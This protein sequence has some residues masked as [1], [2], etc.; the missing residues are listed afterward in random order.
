MTPLDVLVTA[1]LILICDR[2][3]SIKLI[4]AFE[5]IPEPEIFIPTLKSDILVMFLIQLENALVS[6]LMFGKICSLMS[7]FKPQ[8]PLSFALPDK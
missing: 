4:T 3:V 5:G 8:N 6:P 1:A 7:P 2:K